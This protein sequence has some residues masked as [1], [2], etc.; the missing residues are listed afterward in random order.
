MERPNKEPIWNRNA[1]ILPAALYSG[2]WCSESNT[3]ASFSL[4]I[5]AG[6]TSRYGNPNYVADEKVVG[7][8]RE[9][10]LKVLRI[11]D[12]ILGN[13]KYIGGDAFTIADVFHMPYFALLTK[14]GELEKLIEGLP[15]VERWVKE[16]CERDS[17][18]KTLEGW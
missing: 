10:V 7:E 11:Y 5:V 8:A 9:K 3:P 18:K 6:V 15:N 1:L 16:I 13:Q 4:A 14:V 17:V 2:N 12:D